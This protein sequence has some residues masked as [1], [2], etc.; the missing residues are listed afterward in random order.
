MNKRDRLENALA[1]NTVDRVPVTVWRH[2]PGDDQRIA[3]FAWATLTFQKTFDWDF[4]QTTPSSTY[5]V[6]DYGV[7]TE[8]RGDVGGDR[9]PLKRSVT[10]S[11]AWTELKTLDPLRGEQGKYLEA[12]KLIGEGVRDLDV[13]MVA[14]IYSPLSQ[15]AILSG[16]EMM[17]SHI[18]IHADRLRTAL[19]TITEST[20]RFIDAAKRTSVVGIVLVVRHASFSFMSEDEYRALGMPYDLKILETLPSTWWLNVVQLQCRKP[21]FRLVATYPVPGMNWDFAVE[22]TMRDARAFYQGTLCGGLSHEAHLHRGTPAMI[23]DVAREAFEHLGTRRFIL[24]AGD[25]VPVSTPLSNLRA[26]R[27]VVEEMRAG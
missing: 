8:W 10:R 15:A 4:V 2:W 13:P 18:R 14:T 6:A 12:L 9:V 23:R 26:V 11:L 19:N 7:R 27:E 1:G 3:D 24:S 21:M 25:A 16:D 17:L 22:P 5:C 20:L